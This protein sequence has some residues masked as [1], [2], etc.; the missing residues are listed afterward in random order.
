MLDGGG[1]IADTDAIG[2]IPGKGGN[3]RL[4]GLDKADVLKNDI[5]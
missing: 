4:R 2:D 5:P 3:D 1:K